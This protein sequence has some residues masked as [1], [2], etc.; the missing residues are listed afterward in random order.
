MTIYPWTPNG[1]NP[2]RVDSQ[3]FYHH[4]VEAIRGLVRETGYHLCM[5][6]AEGVSKDE[7]YSRAACLYTQ[8]CDALRTI[9]GPEADV[10][11]KRTW[12]PDPQP[13]NSIEP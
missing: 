12:N 4:A 3:V 1:R 7:V 11:I 2:E 8:A 5:L 13:K 9:D 6:Q 10:F